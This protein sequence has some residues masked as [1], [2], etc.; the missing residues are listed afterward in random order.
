MAAHDMNFIDL[1]AASGVT[2]FHF[3]LIQR[4]RVSIFI[5]GISGERAKVATDRTNVRGIQVK[6]HGIKSAATV[7]SLTDLV[8][9]APD[10]E[11]I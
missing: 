6:I 2:N 4:Q 5:D 7:Q 8:R 11:D 1:I 3:D 9:H 10:H